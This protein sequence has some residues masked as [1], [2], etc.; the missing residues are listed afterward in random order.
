MSKCELITDEALTTL[1]HGCPKLTYVAMLHSFIYLNNY[2][3][4]LI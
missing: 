4:S 3:S 2:F 1:S